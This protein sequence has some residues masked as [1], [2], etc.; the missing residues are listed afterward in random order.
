MYY[1]IITTFLLVL[2]RRSAKITGFWTFTGNCYIQ[3][4][5]VVLYFLGP[6]QGN[7]TLPKVL[8]K[9]CESMKWEDD[10]LGVLWG[11]LWGRNEIINAIFKIQK[12]S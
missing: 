2:H 3:K 11:R 5:N 4:K 8:Y 12:L 10:P 9:K 7:P 6:S 1:T